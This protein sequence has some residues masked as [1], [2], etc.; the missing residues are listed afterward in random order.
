MAPDRSSQMNHR[1]YW[2]QRGP[3]HVALAIA[4]LCVVYVAGA[5]AINPSLFPDPAY[6]LLVQ[7]S[8][9]AGA[10][11][12]F[13]TEPLPADIARDHSYFFTVWS[14][15]QHVVPAL[16]QW[17]GLTL[18]QALSAT[19]ILSALMGLAGWYL[20]LR[21][22][23]LERVPAL[24][25]CLTIAT[26]RTFGFSFMVYVGSDQLA[27]AAFP[28]LA[29]AVYAARAS[30]RLC[31]VA[32]AAVLVG[33]FLK[34]SMAIYV[35]AWIAA[36]M[37]ASQWFRTRAGRSLPLMVA[38]TLMLGGTLWLIEWGYVSRGWTPVSYE[39]VWRSNPAAYL[40]PTAMPLLAGTG[41]DDVLSRLFDHPGGP[42]FDYKNSL[43]LLMAI[44]AVAVALMVAELRQPVRRETRLVI[45]SFVVL[46]V[47]VF[48]VMFATGS[49]ASLHLSRHYIIPGVLL[50]P[51]LF[52]RALASRLRWATAGLLA[53]LAVPATYG[54]LSFGA[55]WW[56]HFQQ[57]SAHSDRV[58]I[59]HMTL[60][61]R[62]VQHLAA[63][64]RLLPSNSLVVVPIPSL[65]LEF[66]RTRAMP[67][68]ATSD[69]LEQFEQ[70][71]WAGRPPNIVVVAELA[72]QTPEEIRAW[73]KSF[74]SYDPSQWR[75]ASVD[76]FSFF[77]PGGQAVDVAWLETTLPGAVFDAW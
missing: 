26:S 5:L 55:N 77:V 3:R 34:N 41:V 13:V 6:G 19:N 17:P 15:G 12:N 1:P 11:W 62:V 46:V 66:V 25:T 60:T 49:G 36:T 38:V 10:A 2:E 52:E 50:L 33:F 76:G 29:W 9:R 22:M 8:M 44:A 72:G 47:A 70:A 35:V 31:L 69:G 63:L 64:D 75:R 16:L 24:L 40:L 20:L 42:A 53:L 54:M 71:K 32:P 14:P 37:L 58:G 21:A 27:F 7:K 23:Q 30:W 73:L 67:T 68:S 48:T 65:A 4:A 74:S 18:G 57:R 61:P 39:P 43:P 28:F 59:A 51:L 45:V 56:R